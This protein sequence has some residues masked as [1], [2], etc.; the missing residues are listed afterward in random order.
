MEKVGDKV[1]AK[2]LAHEADVPTV[3][4]YAGG[5][6]ESEERLQEEAEEIG[7]PVLVKAS[8]GGGGRGMRPVQRA[9]DFGGAVRGAGR[10]GGGRRARDAART[11]GG[12]L[13][14]GRSGGQERGGGSVRGGV[15]LSREARGGSTAR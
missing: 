11:E 5:E 1:R 9:A 3:P 10:E 14:R 12:R 7:Y 2:E 15:G 8:A 4:G 13:R 6:D